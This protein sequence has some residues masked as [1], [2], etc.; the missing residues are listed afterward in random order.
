M[1]AVTAIKPPRVT[2]ARIVAIRRWQEIRVRT[3]NQDHVNAHERL[4]QRVGDE[5][6]DVLATLQLVHGDTALETRLYEQLVDL[7]VEGMFLELRHR[8]LSGELDRETYVD[9]LTALADLCRGVGLLPLPSR[10]A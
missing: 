9:E 7:L 3:R 2:D 5:Q 1:Y 6:D 8:H 10:E 4:M